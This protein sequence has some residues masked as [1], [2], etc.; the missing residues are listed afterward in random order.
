[1]SVA[2]LSRRLDLDGWCM[3]DS[4]IPQEEIG[5][6]RDSV[7]ATLE[8]SRDGDPE[9]REEI[10]ALINY[11]QS[12]TPYL[13]DSRVMSILE[14]AL[15]HNFRASMTT[16]IINYPGTGRGG[17]RTGLLTRTVQATS[18]RRIPTQPRIF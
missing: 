9:G 2:D 3:V 6:V 17:T 8:S 13:G 11:D 12:F 15:G 1:M 14:R 18:P 10:N 16:A 7:Q 5:P 4:V